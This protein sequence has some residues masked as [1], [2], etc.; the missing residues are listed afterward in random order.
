MSHLDL[1]DRMVD[2]G[3]V[4]VGQVLDEETDDSRKTGKS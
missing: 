2:L 1:F 3:R 4:L